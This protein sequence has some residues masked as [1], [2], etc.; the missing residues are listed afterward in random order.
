MLQ[1]SVLWCIQDN[2]E[3]KVNDEIL[4]LHKD[5]FVVEGISIQQIKDDTRVVITY[6]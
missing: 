1:I 2:L 3:E 5:G 6:K 4:D